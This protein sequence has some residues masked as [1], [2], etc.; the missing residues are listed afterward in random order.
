MTATTVKTIPRR[1]LL[2][3]YGTGLFADGASNVVV[4]LWVLYLDPSPF[5]FGLV[6]GA[7]SLLPF[8]FSIHGG[9]LMDRIGAR[10]VMMFFAIIG[11]IVPLLFPLLPLIWVA[12]IL[13]LII[14]LTSTMN[15]VGAQTLVGQAARGDPS[16]TWRVSF[17]NKF[18]HFVFPIL[19]GGMW[20]LFGPWGGF[21]V[22]FASALFFW[23]A[24]MMLPNRIGEK[25][26]Q[27]DGTVPTDRRFRAGDLLPRLDDHTR[28]FA[29]L[30]IPLVSVAVAGSVLNIAVG[31]I[32]GSFFIAY[33]R[34][35]GLTGTL[36]GAIFS[37]LNLA[38]LAGTAAVTPLAKRT[39]DVW[40]LNF[41]VVAAI[42]AIAITPLFA[43]FLPLM[44][45]TIIRGFMQGV[46]QPLMIVIPSK[47]VER[48]FQGAVVGLRIALNRLMQT[49][50]PPVMGGVVALVGLQNSF[51][52]VGGALLV[53]SCGLWAIV[54]PPAS[55]D[56][57]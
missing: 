1:T 36:I 9:V 42:A 44:A 47:M 37:G 20:D 34:D 33:M 25:A 23:I 56:G 6:I 55:T 11:V 22:T 39:G 12:G 2:G 7:K 52:W 28:T 46:S 51:Y 5:A 43:A 15:W 45:I 29:L 57:R 41:T 18:G 30:A 19:A 10:R 24:V 17:G 8:L 49:V 54:R 40:M 48:Q 50:L 27:G 16:L 38:G 35:I 4:P 32:Q 26:A 53:I 21:G 13:N 3:I 31:A 14:G